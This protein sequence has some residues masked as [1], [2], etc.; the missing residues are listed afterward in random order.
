MSN[1]ISENM[2]TNNKGGE[3]MMMNTKMMMGTRYQV[4]TDKPNKLIYISFDDIDDTTINYPPAKEKEDDNATL[5]I[6]NEEDTNCNNLNTEDT[7][8][9]STI[10]QSIPD[11]VLQ[12]ERQMRK[13]K[14]ADRAS[15]TNVNPEDHLHII[16]RDDDIVVTNKPSGILCVPGVNKNRSLLDLVFEINNNGDEDGVE[17]RSEDKLAKDSMIVHRLDMDTSGIVIFATTREAMSELH[18]AF[19]ERTGTKKTYEALLVGWFDINKWIESQDD[20]NDTNKVME[21]K[22]SDTANLGGGEINLP[23][24]RD[25][26]HPPFMRV[27]TPGSESE[28][29]LAVKDLNSAGYKKLMAKKP[30]ASTTQFKVLSLEHWRGHPVT[31]VELTP[32]TGRQV[33][34]FIYHVHSSVQ[35]EVSV[36][37]ILYLAF[38]C[39]HL[40]VFTKHMYL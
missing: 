10:Q 11:S 1:T 5:S 6:S 40:I 35:Y 27:S 28:A 31:R 19:R 36:I 25:H 7:L 4:K 24:Q 12:Y 38:I 37:L 3:V 2:G 33:F 8:D 26:R 17:R 32:I 23:L 9:I 14:A 15:K 22:G 29:Q 21:E 18:K 20:D 16:Y 39:F 30:K 34:V 13:I